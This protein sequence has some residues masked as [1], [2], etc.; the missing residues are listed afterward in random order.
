MKILEAKGMVHVSRWEGFELY[1]RKVMDVEKIPGVAVAISENGEVIYQKG[2]GVRDLTTNGP[3]TPETIFGVASITKSF[4][5]LA[6]MKLVEEGKLQLED[7][8]S[9][10]LPDF[11]LKDC[12]FTDEIT[13]HH[14]L[15]HTTGLG[16]MERLEKLNGF[17]EHLRYLNEIDHTYLGRPA[18][19]ICYNNDMFLLLGAVI[20]RITGENYQDFIRRLIINPLGM[21][22]TTYDLQ[23][24]KGFENVTVPYVLEEGDPKECPWPTLGNY[25]VGGGIRSTVLDLLKYGEAYVGESG[26]IVGDQYVRKMTT[27]IHWVSGNSHYG[28]A[29]KITPDYSGVTLI[30]HGGGQPGVSSNFGFILERGITVAVLTNLSNVSADAIWLAAVNAVLGLP[31]DQKRSVEPQYDM[32]IEQ[33]KRM[34]GTYRSGE[35]AEVVISLNDDVATATI[36]NETFTLRSSDDSTLVIEKT[37][38][39]IRFFFD[40]ENDA[41][42]M[43]LGLRMLVKQ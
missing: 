37:E 13:I 35:G 8:V 1:V 12:G 14:L 33:L 34:V 29:L 4:T 24:L 40:G 26:K 23:E 9:K 19:F 11:K 27:P 36:G 28:Y 42:A 39:P 43:F 6:I 38:K 17:D 31:I 3:V 32:D 5:A 25:A 16:T 41:W 22:R 7:P 2:F 15:S 10:H 21:E 20:E 30:E 18:E